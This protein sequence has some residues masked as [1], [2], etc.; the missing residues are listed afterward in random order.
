M[1][2]TWTLVRASTGRR[3]P[4]CQIPDP[5]R[6]PVTAMPVDGITAAL[7]SADDSASPGA[8]ALYAATWRPRIR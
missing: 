3:A 8:E 1:A 4:S 6:H 2:G 5:K 7:S